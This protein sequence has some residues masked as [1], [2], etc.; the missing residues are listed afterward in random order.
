MHG[1]EKKY[2]SYKGTIGKI[3]SNVLQR[4][5]STV[6]LTKKWATDISEINLF[7]QKRL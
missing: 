2:H 7:G 3:A 5:F 1:K 4:D 6:V